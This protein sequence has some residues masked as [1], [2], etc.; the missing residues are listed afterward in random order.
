MN[1]GPLPDV[2]VSAEPEK[3]AAK[4]LREFTQVQFIRELAALM[5]FC[6]M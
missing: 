6:D 4:E 2:D 1:D 3:E 5:G